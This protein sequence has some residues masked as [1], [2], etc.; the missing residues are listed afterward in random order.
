MADRNMDM[1][2]K[3]HEREKKKFQDACTHKRISD[4]MDYMWAPGH[5]GLPVK[6]CRRCNKIMETQ[7]FEYPQDGLLSIDIPPRE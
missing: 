6:I 2:Y 7:K 1:M 5:M 4:W 3:R